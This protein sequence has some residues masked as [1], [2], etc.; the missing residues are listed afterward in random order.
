MT[1][2][3]VPS[4]YRSGGSAQLGSFFREQALALSKYG[5]NVI[6]ADAT[7]QGRDNILSKDMFRLRKFNDNGVI[8]YS[9]ITPA[10]GATRTKFGGIR[11]YQRNLKILLEY[12]LDDGVDIDIIH[13]HS[14]FPA[15]YSALQLA[16]EYGIPLIVTEHSGG[17][18]SNTLDEIKYSWLK[19]TVEESDAFIC[20]GNKL[21]ESIIDLTETKRSIYVIPN[22]VS[23]LFHPINK[24]ETNEFCFVSV[25]NLIHSKRFDLTLRAF[26]KSFACNDRVRLKIIGDGELKNK[27]ISLACELGVNEKVDFLGRLQRESVAREM[28]KCDAFVLPSDFETFGVVYIEALASGLPVIATRNGGAEDIVTDKNGLLVD[29]DNVDQLTNAMK[30][31]YNNISDF[32]KEELSK[33]CYAKFGEQSVCDRILD[34]YN[35]IKFNV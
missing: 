5:V 28:Q 29:I 22:M 17:I 10:L 7:L 30:T 34:V 11:K 12:I 26:A 35:S 27:L 1:V 21:K 14:F 31:L 32:K 4:W 24:S 9:H 19:E 33:S 20:V 6:V 18:I 16:R 8:T 2:L 13:A 23:T 15:G 3:V 25:G